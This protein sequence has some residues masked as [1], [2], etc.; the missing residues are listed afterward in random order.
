MKPR[1]EYLHQYFYPLRVM[2]LHVASVIVYFV[3]SFSTDVTIMSEVSCMQL[4]VAIQLTFRCVSFV[5]QSTGKVVAIVSVLEV[6]SS[7][8]CLT[9]NKRNKTVHHYFIVPKESNVI[10]ITFDHI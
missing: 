5:T 2:R 4:H 1:K 9:L 6:V 10:V 8:L 3:E 7:R